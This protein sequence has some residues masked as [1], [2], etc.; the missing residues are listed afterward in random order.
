[1]IHVDDV[2]SLLVSLIGNE[3]SIG[4]VY[5]AAGA[6]FCSILACIHLMGRAAGEAPKIVHVPME[7]LTEL[8]QPIVHWGEG[9]SGGTV[10]SIAKALDHLD[11]TP[12]FGLQAAYED[13]YRWFASVGRGRYEFDFSTDDEVLAR[14]GYPLPSV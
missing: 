11:W 5:N 4:E 12:L 1:M 7:V 8:E 10:F 2:A 3:R 6:E 13:S 9:T 14:L